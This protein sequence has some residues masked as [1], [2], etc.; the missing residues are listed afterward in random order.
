MVIMEVS[1]N[2]IVDRIVSGPL[3]TLANVVG[4]DLRSPGPGQRRIPTAADSGVG[5]IPVRIGRHTG[6]GRID[7]HLRAVREDDKH[8]LAGRRIDEMNIHHALLPGRDRFPDL[9]TG[10][11]SILATVRANQKCVGLVGTASDNRENP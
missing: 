9:Q 3:H 5:R 6:T 7:Q 4:D 10:S 11:R 2:H 1:D 8:T